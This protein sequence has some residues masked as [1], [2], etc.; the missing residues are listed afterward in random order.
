MESAVSPGR[1]SRRARFQATSS[2]VPAAV[3]DEDPLGRGLDARP[4]EGL[5]GDA[6]PDAA[7]LV[8]ARASASEILAVPDTDL[9]P[10]NIEIATAVTTALG[11]WPH[12]LR[13]AVAQLPG[14]Q[15]L[16]TDAA[17]FAQRGL[18]DAERLN[19]LKMSAGIHPR[20]HGR[21]ESA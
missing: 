13:D 20:G 2:R 16:V 9:A 6:P 10:I 7:V 15:L 1:G 8:H 11:A 18:V 12:T 4:L 14:R 5:Q 17:S 19:E 3:R 21:R